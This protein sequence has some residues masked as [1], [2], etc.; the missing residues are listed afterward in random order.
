MLIAVNRKAVMMWRY[1]LLGAISAILLLQFSGKNA[2]V[3][4]F[5]MAL[6]KVCMHGVNLILV[7]MVPVY[8]KEN[9]NVYQRSGI[10]NFKML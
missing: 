4:I 1:F 9:W 7:C 6:L 3:C 5:W 10:L 8:F 2:M